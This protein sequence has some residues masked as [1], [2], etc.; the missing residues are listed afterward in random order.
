[1]TGGVISKATVDGM[2]M[3]LFKDFTSSFEVVG[4][5][6]RK[7]MLN[8]D[9]CVIGMGAL[10]GI[11]GT[12]KASVCTQDY[13]QNGKIFITGV[14]YSD[15]VIPDGFYTP[16][17]G[18]REVSITATLATPPYT[19]LQTTSMMA[20]GY[21]I[22]VTA[23]TW[24]L[25]ATGGPLGAP[26]M[27]VNGVVVGG[28]N[29]KVDFSHSGV[30]PTVMPAF[31]MISGGGKGAPGAWAVALKKGIFS[32]GAKSMAQGDVDALTVT[33]DGQTFFALADRTSTKTKLDKVS[34]EISGVTIK[35]TAK[36]S[37]AI[38]LLKRTIKVSLKSAPGIDPTDGYVTIR[39]N[40]PDFIGSLTSKATVV[41]TK[42]VLKPATGEVSLP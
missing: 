33:V 6:H 8:A 26:E 16:G 34:G 36:N 11:F 4:R 3:L 42:V 37:L 1:V 24:N 25:A 28:T 2:H 5:G 22:E 7:A 17:E 18:L 40:L 15:T 9:R 31:T 27:Q 35:D 29:Q 20:G 23:G 21:A 19:V 41:G 39:V 38:D 32:T 10:A 12:K 14:C 30:K 13:L